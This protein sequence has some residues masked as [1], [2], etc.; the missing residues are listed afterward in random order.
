MSSPNVFS[1]YIPSHGPDDASIMVVG[2]AGGEDEERLGYP[3][4]GRSG[5][6]MSQH[7]ERQGKRRNLSNVESGGEPD[8]RDLLHEPL[9]VPSKRE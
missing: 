4:V 7:F 1:T 5:Q 3:F 9:K 6:L 2:E 8:S